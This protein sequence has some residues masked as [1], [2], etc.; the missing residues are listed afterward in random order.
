MHGAKCASME[1]Q[2]FV[3]LYGRLL[4][5]ELVVR[6]YNH[7]VGCFLTQ[8][9]TL[10][11]PCPILRLITSRWSC[12]SLL[13]N[14]N[15]IRVD[16]CNVLILNVFANKTAQNAMYR[17]LQLSCALINHHARPKIVDAPLTVIFVI[18]QGACHCLFC[19]NRQPILRLC[20]S[21]NKSL[22]NYLT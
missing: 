13:D 3:V 15:S 8:K 7:C 12:N 1:H 2:Q 10:Y 4:K 17:H 11:S 19:L 16:C 14:H 22:F 5:S 9:R 6:I 21:K 20:I 18:R